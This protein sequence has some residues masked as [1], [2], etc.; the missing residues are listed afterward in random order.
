M[1]R[2][3][4][5]PREVYRPQWAYSTPKGFHDEGWIMGPFPL[6]VPGTGALAL[7]LPA[8]L[9]DDVPFLI[10]AIMID[11]LLGTAEA[12]LP[13]V[14]IFAGAL[15]RI[16]DTYGNPLTA[17]GVNQTGAAVDDL[18]LGLGVWANQLNGLNAFG[19]VIEP[20]IEC[21]PGGSIIFD[22]L[23]P[24]SGNAANFFDTIGGESIEFVAAVMGP[25]GNAFTITLID[26][27]APSV[28]L[29]VVVVG[30][31]NVQVTLATNPGSVITTTFA[32]LQAIINGTPAVLALMYA[33]IFGPTPNAVVTALALTPLG[34]GT[35][36]LPV[37]YNGTFIGV[38]RFPDC[39]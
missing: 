31:V 24:T 10:R 6:T 21:S 39:L 16:R 27:G 30:G 14:D 8:Q 38:K 25:A 11:G 32:E 13:P 12:D 19:F 3:C 28:P 2:G 15:V 4:Y 17:A 7:N 22:I 35:N 20:E 26:P 36:G 1:R 34:S 37:T 9:D 33:L 18:V 23:A 5:D 29:S